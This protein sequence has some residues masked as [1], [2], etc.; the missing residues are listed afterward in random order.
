[1]R[2]N[3]IKFLVLC[4]LIGLLSISTL[5]IRNTNRDEKQS[6]LIFNNNGMSI[7]KLLDK[8]LFVILIY[9]NVEKAIDEYYSDYFT[10]T[11]T[12]DP[13]HYKFLNLKKLPESNFSYIIKLEVMPY[14]GP[15]LTVGVDHI[16]LKVDFNGT[17][18]EKHEHIESH[19]LP[20]HYQG[21]IKKK[22]TST[23]TCLP[24]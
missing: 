2:K 14:V 19:E 16:T 10:Y 6:K 22:K 23:N 17:N 21:I 3:P 7:E 18:V 5:E 11:P 24:E 8:N 9:P 4:L 12:S 20:P 15:H 1:M 13:W